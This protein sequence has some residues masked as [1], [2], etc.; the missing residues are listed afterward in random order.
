ME[1][2][3]ETSVNLSQDNRFP[4]RDLNPGPSEYEGVL[5]NRLRRSVKSNDALLHEVHEVVAY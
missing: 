1:G 5:T 3:R 4:D 2:L